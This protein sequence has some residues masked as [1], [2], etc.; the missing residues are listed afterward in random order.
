MTDDDPLVSAWAL[1][2]AA[3]RAGAAY[4]PTYTEAD[5]VAGRLWEATARP[6]AE[7]GQ[8]ARASSNAASR[9]RR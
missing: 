3:T 2:V 8:T 5:R 7:P 4:V 6:P 9:S 1:R